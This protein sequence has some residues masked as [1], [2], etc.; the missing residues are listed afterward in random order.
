[1]IKMGRIKQKKNCMMC[2]SPIL[3]RNLNAIYCKQCSYGRR[4]RY[5]RMKKNK[6]N[7]ENI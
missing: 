4:E 6:A 7:G 2:N 1:M 3:N 5:L